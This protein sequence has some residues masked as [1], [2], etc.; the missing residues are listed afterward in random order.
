MTIGQ[1]IPDFNSHA[2]GEPSSIRLIRDTALR[3][4]A[5]HGTEAASL[6]TIAKAAGV[7]VG[8]VQHHF[9][10]KAN[11][12]Q[13]VDDH[14]MT[15]LNESLAGPLAGAPGDPV[16]DAAERVTALFAGNIEIV[17]YLSRALIDSTP[18][19]VRVFDGL[20][21]I[22]T[23]YWNEIKEQGLTQPGL[24]PTWMVLSPL[25][26]VLGSFMLRTHLSRHLPDAVNTPIQLQ[27]WR[28]AT[29][30]IIGSGQLRR[31]E[32][33]PDSPPAPAAL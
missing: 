22:S 4:F 8:L 12:V 15:V 26:L 24:D 19:G 6:R 18:I 13:A 1:V 14:V 9:G 29:E 2:A 31:P 16:A 17:D 7:S 27:R 32:Q 11:L 30:V 25:T 28:D 23:G 3:L 5:V 21:E 10:T 20:I 33:E